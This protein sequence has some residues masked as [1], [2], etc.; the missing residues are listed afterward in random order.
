MNQ[1]QNNPESSVPDQHAPFA[2]Q[3]AT[4]TTGYLWM[5]L[6]LLMSVTIFEGYDV[7]I[8]HLC[9]PDIARTFHL[10]DRAVGMMASLVRLGGLAAFVLVMASDRI[11]RKPI[12]SGTVLFYTMFTL[13][14]ALS[15][16]LGS[17]TLFQSLAQLF[18]SAEFSIAIIMISEELPDNMRGRGIAA[19]HMVGLF[20]VVAGGG[21]YGVVADSRWGWRGMYFIGIIPLLLVA[22]LRRGLK[23]TARFEALKSAR[24][25]AANW[26]AEIGAALRNAIEP[27]RGPYRGRVLLVALLWNCV[28]LVGSPA[29]TF[30]SLYAKR[31]H[32]WTSPQ[33]GH[34]VVLAYVIG[35]LGHIVAGWSLDRVGR[36]PTTSVSYVLGAFAILALFQTESHGAMLTALVVTVFA[37]QSA[38]TATATYS[39]ELFPTEIRATSYSLTVQLFG[40]IAALLTPFTIGA[41]SKSLGGLGNAVAVVSISPIIGAIVVWRFAPETRGM[42]LEQLETR[43]VD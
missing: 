34:A 27:I 17:F 18:L 38:R 16:G 28:G 2:P 41:L 14:T 24:T 7:S 21:L 4:R 9:T 10:N 42:S 25:T 15:T 32:H 22:F 39:A 29:V 20:G 26:T 6:G 19:L 13:L 5:L 36:K 40:Q 23:E 8:F 35:A 43:T 1:P 33:I 3:S 37:F 12:V 11:G 30:F 31:D